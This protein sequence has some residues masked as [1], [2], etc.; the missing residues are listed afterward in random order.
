MGDLNDKQGGLHMG[1]KTRRSKAL[2]PIPTVQTAQALVRLYGRLKGELS[3]AG[4]CE[5]VLIPVG[6]VKLYMRAASSVCNPA[7]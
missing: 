6:D 7:G 3:K 5:D 2:L 1:G 4:A